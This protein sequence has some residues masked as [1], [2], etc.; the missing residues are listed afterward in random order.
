MDCPCISV[1]VPAYKM[2]K[3][4]RQCLDSIIN[5]TLKNIEIIIVD[6]GDLDEC[7]AIIDEYEARDNRIKTIHEKSGGYGASM[8]K[9]FNLASG[10]YFGIVEADDFIDSNM[11][12]ELY[13]IAKNNDADIVK[14]DFYYYT[15]KNNTSRKTGKIDK[16]KANKVINIKSEPSILKIQPSVWSA[17]Y[18]RDFLMNSCVRFLETKG[19]SYQDTSFA[20]KILSKANRVVLT[21]NAYLHY[22]ID[23]ELSS[24][25]NKGKVF[26]ICDEYDEIT[27]FLNENPE[28]KAIVNYQK[29]INQYNAYIWNLSRIALESRAEFIEKFA[30]EFKNYINDL[31]DKFYKKINKKEVELLVSNKEKFE[32]YI[33]KKL[34][35]KEKK[36][37]RSKLFSIRINSSR[38]DIVLFGKQILAYE[39]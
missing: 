33:N 12:E 22:R 24:V 16:K 17:I 15:T 4:L 37:K 9:A 26:A 35:K 25:N 7:R 8:N 23:N 11:Y 34:A 6:E 38:V 32:N 30:L 27:R 31:D 28:I 39:I 1:L 2:E 3:Y 21:T 14:S 10:E 13:N 29:L 20:F 19:G 18:K 5:Q 36:V